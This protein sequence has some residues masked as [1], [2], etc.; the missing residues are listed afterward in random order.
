MEGH[1][2]QILKTIQ[3]MMAGMDEEELGKHM[4]LQ[5]VYSRLSKDP[6]ALYQKFDA[7]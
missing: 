4:S 7:K 3:N 2:S 6:N 5:M 1:I